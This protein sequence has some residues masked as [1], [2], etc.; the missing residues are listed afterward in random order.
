MSLM[1]C[2]SLI[3]SSFWSHFALGCRQIL[4]LIY[5]LWPVATPTLLWR[6]SEQRVC[7]GADGSIGRSQRSS[8]WQSKVCECYWV[9]KIKWLKMVK[10]HSQRKSES[11][12]LC[13]ARMER[14]FSLISEF[15][16]LSL[17]YIKKSC[18]LYKSPPLVW[19][20]PSWSCRRQTWPYLDE[21]D[22]TD[23]LG[24]RPLLQ[25][26]WRPSVLANANISLLAW[27]WFLLSVILHYLGFL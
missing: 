11:F 19:Q 23:D 6:R 12:F 22:L 5:V 14:L 4:P 15:I 24:T 9:L 18:R 10:R 16:S 2:D 1:R 21:R 13:C 3:R 25:T 26:T 17:K 7:G 20:S 8:F 27:S